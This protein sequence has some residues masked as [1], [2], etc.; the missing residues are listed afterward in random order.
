M[1]QYARIG[2]SVEAVQWMR[3]GDHPDVKLKSARLGWPSDVQVMR[4]GEVCGFIDRFGD[5]ELVTPGDWIVGP[6]GNASVVTKEEFER[7]FVPVVN[8]EDQ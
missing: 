4:S 2:D 6:A 3:P 8:K 1:A 5:D 7:R